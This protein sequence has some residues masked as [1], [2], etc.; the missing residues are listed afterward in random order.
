MAVPAQRLVLRQDQNRG[1]S[2]TEIKQPW[3]D[4]SNPFGP[5]GVTSWASPQGLPMASPRRLR[6][7]LRGAAYAVCSA[8]ASAT[9]TMSAM[10]EVSWKSLGV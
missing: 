10:I 4:A 6:T 7:R 8:A 2:A 3:L 5:T 9:R 1:T